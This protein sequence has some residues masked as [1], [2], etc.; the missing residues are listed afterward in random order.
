MEPKGQVSS[1]P[2]IGYS[3]S[4]D[5]P[6]HLD[7]RQPQPEESLRLY[8]NP[9]SLRVNFDGRNHRFIKRTF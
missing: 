9:Q 3:L 1:A 4:F 7:E 5:G 2:E 8:K 6:I